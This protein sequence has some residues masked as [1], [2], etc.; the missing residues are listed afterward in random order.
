M[1]VFRATSQGSSIGMLLWYVMGDIAYYHLGAYSDLGY[2]LRASFALFSFAIDYFADIGLR[3]LNLGAGAGTRGAADDGLS[4]FKKG[5]SNSER[6]SYFCG[7][8]F[9]QAKYREI[10]LRRAGLPEAAYFPLYR[11]GEF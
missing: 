2:D 5:W 1:V 4:R 8:V 6:T 9:D 3:W 10:S 7:R 11:Y